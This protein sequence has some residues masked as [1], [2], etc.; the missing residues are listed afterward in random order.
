MLSL[1]YAIRKQN[2]AHL[3]S[4]KTSESTRVLLV[5]PVAVFQDLEGALYSFITSS[6]RRLGKCVRHFKGEILCCGYWGR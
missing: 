2:N 4:T 1:F 5:R 6:N 3:W